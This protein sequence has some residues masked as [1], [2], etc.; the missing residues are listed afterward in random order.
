MHLHE[1]QTKSLLKNYGI[2]SPPFF[3]LESPEQLDSIWQKLG[4]KEA[5]LKAQ[6]HAGGRGKGGGILKVSSL[7]EAKKG[8]IKLLGHPLVTPQ[9]GPKGLLVSKV[10]ITEAI[11]IQKEYYIAA[12][13]DRREKK[14]FLIVS[15][16]GG[17]DIEETAHL[18]PERI[19]KE[20][21]PH[22]E[23]C[24]ITNFFA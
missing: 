14:P 13:I 20:A 11:S 4:K 7:E 15:S 19:L 17:M 5:I 24:G 9:T 22:Q 1:Y 2:D 12:L 16:E 10:M 6:V 8:A 21:I 3:V 18:H 23:K